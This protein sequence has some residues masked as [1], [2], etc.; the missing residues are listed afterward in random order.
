MN[1]PRLSSHPSGRVSEQ[2]GHAARLVARTHTRH[3]RACQEETEV[4]VNTT[5]DTQPDSYDNCIQQRTQ[6]AAIARQQPGLRS[7]F[8]SAKKNQ[9]QTSQRIMANGYPL[10]PSRPTAG[11]PEIAIMALVAPLSHLPPEF[12]PMNLRCTD[13]APFLLLTTRSQPPSSVS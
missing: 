11:V 4:H 5:R 10:P 1:R 8:G 6:I 7:A 9:K 12:L 13:S 2:A 3:T